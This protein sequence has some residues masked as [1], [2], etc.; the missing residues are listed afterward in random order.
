MRVLITG[1]GTRLS[2]ELA[3]SLS[4]DRDVVLTGRGG[5]PA[6]YD[7]IEVAHAELGHD[8]S[9]R[10]LVRGVDAIVHNGEADTGPSASEQLDAA[11]RCTYNL[12]QAASAEGVR[13]FV[14]LSSLSVMGRYGEDHVV[15]E[16]WRPAP[17]T[18]PP[19]LAY[20]LGEHVC[21]EF[22][23]E[24]QIAV[25]CLR[26]GELAWDGEPPSTSALYPDDAAHAVSRALDWKADEAEILRFWNGTFDPTG[27]D[28][29]HIQ[30]EVPDQRYLIAEARKR[31]G[32]S[33]TP[34]P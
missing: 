20:H 22:G 14:Y 28:I 3:A 9:T 6:A 17:D 1:A 7:G 31:L 10:E 18:E 21:R 19:E 34:R 5:V 11:M 16:R 25:V 32:Y 24:R 33:P 4:A 26:L 27:W 8:D 23:R 2:R 29:F 15:T 12:L 30:S 13:R